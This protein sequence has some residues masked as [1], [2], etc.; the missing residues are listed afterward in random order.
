MRD[1]TIEEIQDISGGAFLTPYHSGLLKG[2]IGG[3]LAGLFSMSTYVYFQPHCYEKRTPFIHEVP[4]Y[5][6]ETNE[7]L[8]INSTPSVKIETVCY[9]FFN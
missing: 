8:G 6:P 1:V 2:G 5:D 9:P 7:L 3:F 4:V